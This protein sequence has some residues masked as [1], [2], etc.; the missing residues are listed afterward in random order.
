MVVALAPGVV[1]DELDQADELEQGQ[2]A[3]PLLVSEHGTASPR[4]LKLRRRRCFHRVMSGLEKRG[5]GPYR[6]MMLSTG[7][8]DKAAVQRAFRGLVQWG[9]RRGLL[10]D[11]VRVPELT[12]E[13]FV[14]LHIAF[15]GKFIDRLLLMAEWYKLVGGPE[16][17]P[18]MKY[19]YLQAMRSKRGSAHYLAKY[20]VKDTELALFRGNYSWSWGWVWRGFVRDWTDLKRAWAYAND[21][22]HWGMSYGQLLAQWRFFCR[23][24]LAP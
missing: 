21:V 8:T 11:Y 4:A 6:L 3:G 24:G 10:Q 17:M 12:E 2:G 1:Q 19:V 22:L 16:Y 13:G 20:M 23:V 15:R 9:K 18:G 14:H 5:Q 7:M